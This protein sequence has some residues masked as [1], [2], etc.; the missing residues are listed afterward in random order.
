MFEIVEMNICYFKFICIIFFSVLYVKAKSWFI[1]IFEFVPEFIHYTSVPYIF[2]QNGDVNYLSVKVSTNWPGYCN[3]NEKGTYLI[4]QY[5]VICPFPLITALNRV[6][7]LWNRLCIYSE[8]EVY[9]KY[10]E[11]HLS[12][13]D[14]NNITSYWVPPSN[15]NCNM[16]SYWVPQGNEDSNIPS[17]WVPHGNEGSNISSYW[18]PQANENCNISSYSVPQGNEDSNISSYWVPLGNKGSNIIINLFSAPGD[19]GW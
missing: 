10:P 3:V 12:N 7:I 1:F 13:L 2:S 18:V 11:Q 6:G 16:S 19:W 14:D 17:H 8:V 5:L 15:E 9:T 4:F